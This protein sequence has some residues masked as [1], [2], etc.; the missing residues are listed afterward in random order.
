MKP[1]TEDQIKGKFHEVKGKVKEK[2]GH[3]T[4][5][6]D[7]EGEGQDEKVAG[8]VQKKIGQVEKVFEE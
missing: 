1:S 3:A 4:N 5:D 2:V 6:R 7:L 8:K